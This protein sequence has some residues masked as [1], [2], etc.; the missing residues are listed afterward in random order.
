MKVVVPDKSEIGVKSSGGEGG[1][2]YDRFDKGSGRLDAN[3]AF[4]DNDFGFFSVLKFGSACRTFSKV[5]CKLFFFF[6]SEFSVDCCTHEHHRFVTIHGGQVNKLGDGNG[7][8]T[9]FGVVT[10]F[11]GIIFKFFTQQFP[12]SVQT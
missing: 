6:R 8:L 3:D 5:L 12:A 10:M 1:Q 2:L 11:S 7:S 4:P 9:S